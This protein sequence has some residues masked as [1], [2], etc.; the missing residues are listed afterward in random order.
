MGRLMELLRRPIAG[1]PAYGWALVVAGTI[2]AY[3]YIQRYREGTNAVKTAPEAFPYADAGEPSDSGDISGVPSTPDRDIPITTNPAWIRYTTDRLVAESHSAVDVGN[4]LNK[5]LSGLELTEQE[6]ALWN[7]AVRRFG[8]PPEGHP[9]IVVISKP[10]TP[11]ATPPGPGTTAP[12]Y[13]NIA[14][15]FAWST[16]IGWVWARTKL[17]PTHSL[18]FPKIYALNPGF[19]AQRTY[20]SRYGVRR[21]KAAGTVRIK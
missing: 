5:A 10:G 13:V 2:V 19:L 12:V 9:P 21:V 8:A 15:D 3:A 20:V 1:I 4:A 11:P 18:T 16:F 14:K 6:A 7:L 17:D